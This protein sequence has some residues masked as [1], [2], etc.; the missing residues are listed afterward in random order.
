MVVV[1]DEYDALGN[2]RYSFVR[3]FKKKKLNT[4][5]HPPLQSNSPGSYSQ[6][7]NRLRIK[8]KHLCGCLICQLFRRDKYFQRTLPAQWNFVYTISSFISRGHQVNMLVVCGL[9]RKSDWTGCLPVKIRSQ[10]GIKKQTIPSWN[11]RR[12]TVSQ[13]KIHMALNDMRAV[14][15][16]L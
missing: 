1:T 10:K 8:R 15:L 3:L 11:H 14:E 12:H 6:A 16:F 9:D 4:G 7:E 5:K 13:M 2:A